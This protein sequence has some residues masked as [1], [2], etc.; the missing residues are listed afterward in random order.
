M[1]E[2]SERFRTRAKQCR[3]LA[4]LARD[5][6]SRETLSQMAVELD[7]E[8]DTIDDDEAARRNEN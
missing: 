3:D 8:A 6:Y 1:S 2:D 7:N 5:S 4:A